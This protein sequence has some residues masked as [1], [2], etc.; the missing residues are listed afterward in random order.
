MSFL[1]RV[2]GITTALAWL[3]GAYAKLDLNATDNVVVY[4]G[5]D[6]TI[7]GTRDLANRDCL[8]AKTLWKQPEMGNRSDCLTIA[9]VSC[10][11]TLKTACANWQCLDDKIDV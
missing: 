9:K 10:A 3:G 8:Q 1:R 2:F 6:N 4:W 11:L 7:T 5:M